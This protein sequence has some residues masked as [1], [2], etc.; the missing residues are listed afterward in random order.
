MSK[1]FT[2]FARMVEYADFEKEGASPEYAFKLTEG[3]VD[4]G[5]PHGFAKVV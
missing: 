4:L 3:Q 1:W 5:K 2:G